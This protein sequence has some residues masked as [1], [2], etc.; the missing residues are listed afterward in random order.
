MFAGYAF[1]IRHIGSTLVAAVIVGFAGCLLLRMVSLRDLIKTTVIYGAGIAL[2]ILPYA[3]RNLVVF[4]VLQVLPPPAPQVVFLGNIQVYFQKLGYMFF[5]NGSLGGGIF[6][7][8][9]GIA[10]YYTVRF[11]DRVV[12]KDAVFIYGLILTCYFLFDSFFLIVY[13]SIYTSMERIAERYLIQCAWIFAGGLIYGIYLVLQRSFRSQPML[14]KAVAGFLLF[15]FVMVQVFQASDFYIA[16]RPLKKLSQKI[17]PYAPLI[18]DLAPDYVVVSNVYDMS[19]YFSKRVVRALQD[20]G[21]GDLID[22]LGTKRKFAVFIV[23]PAQAF[24]SYRYNPE[25]LSAP[26]YDKIFSDQTVDLFV[27]R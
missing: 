19:F 18:R 24:E 9:I 15:F 2:V 1:L 6:T 21:P 5:A 13:M 14:V 22:I 16:Q 4:G 3:V 12:R 25:W 27:P 8:L 10:I 20:Y 7:A 23:K 11:K 26:G 17:E